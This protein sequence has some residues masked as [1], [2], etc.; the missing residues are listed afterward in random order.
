MSQRQYEYR[1]KNWKSKAISRRKENDYLKRRE[2]E[3]IKSRDSWKHKYQSE[4]LAHK[5]TL[6][7]GKKAKG[8]HYSLEL[9]VLVME[10]YKYGSMSLRSCRHTISCIYICLGLKGRIPCHNSIR[11]W[12]CK[13]GLQRVKNISVATSDYVIYVDESISFG[14]EKILLVLGVN[15]DE[16]PKHRSLN[17]AD[18]EVLD[19]S[20]GQEWKGTQIA[21]VLK[22]VTVNKQIR[23]VVSDEGNNLKKAYKLLNY[24]HIKD[25]THLFANDLK[26]LYQSDEDFIMFSQLIGKLRQKWNLSKANSQYMPPSMRGK[27]RFANIFPSINWAKKMLQNWEDLPS[28]VQEEIL[29]LRNKETFITGLIQVEKTFKTVCS[30]LKNH[31]FGQEQ[32]Q[33][34]MNDLAEIET[35]IWDGLQPKA[36]IF[37]ENIKAYLEHLDVKSKTLN[38]TF[39]L[40]SSDIIESYFG[41]FKAKINANSRSGLTEF[42]FT[43]ATFG[44][45]FSIDEAQNAL[46]SIKCKQL[47]LYR[48]KD[49]VA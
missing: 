23:Y 44:K 32:K 36:I 34:L 10:L 38:E 4:K 22:K 25:C 40:C 8:H 24:N 21:D 26:R 41:K 45:T 13:C 2:K 49:K 15:I 28:I 37:I 42:I 17:H 35:Q 29:F 39:L 16:I 3:L 18:M 7:K 1:L 5:N 31:G 11:N 19:V 27:L 14:S 47:K 43:I 9:V 48:T 30:K 46:E 6:L 33:E 20:I 12:I